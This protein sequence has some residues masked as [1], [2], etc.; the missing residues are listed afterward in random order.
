MKEGGVFIGWGPS[1]P[2]RERKSVEL[3]LEA[4]RYF[5]GLVAEG[6]LISVEPV[7]L[8]PHG[9][10]LEGFIFVRGEQEEITRLRTEDEV[11]RLM[12]KAGMVLQNLRVVGAVTG[13]AL[14]QHLQWYLQ[15]V[16][17]TTRRR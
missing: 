5:M 10:D 8:E 13:S 12:V 2:G 6:R 14:N 11:R 17:Q 3:F 4:M 15:A 9:G 16:R 1:L 7:F